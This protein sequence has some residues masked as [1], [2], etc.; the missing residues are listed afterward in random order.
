LTP[1]SSHQQTSTILRLRQVE[2]R[3]GLCRSSIY[4][5]MSRG[6][7]QF[8]PLFPRPIS[9]SSSTCRRSAIGFFQHEI[10]LWLAQR[11]AA[12]SGA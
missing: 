6:G 12:R 8:D 10:D 1:G 7:K 4:A 3:I 2:A 9:L 5:R 11:S